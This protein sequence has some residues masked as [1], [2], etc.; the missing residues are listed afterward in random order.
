MAVSIRSARADDA[1]RVAVLLDRLGYPADAAEVTARLKDWLDD[2]H[3]RLLVTEM[4]G[5]VAGFA[6]LHAFPLIEHSARRARL[7]AL[8]V[9]DAFHGKGVGR[10]LVEAAEDQARAWGC[11]DLEITSSRHRTGAHA[12]YARLGYTDTCEQAAR[13]LKP[14]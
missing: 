11:R 12:F 6:A 5:L 14:L 3:S 8:V 2:R 9:D 7:V 1:P 10:T 4:E 13:F